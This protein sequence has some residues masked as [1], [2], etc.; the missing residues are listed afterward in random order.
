ME[1]LDRTSVAGPSTTSESRPQNLSASHRDFTSR[2]RT[3][4]H[5]LIPQNS[6]IQKDLLRNAR[7]VHDEEAHIPELGQRSSQGLQVSHQTRV[8]YAGRD[9]PDGGPSLV[10]VFYLQDVFEAVPA[11]GLFVVLHIVLPNGV[12]Q[13]V[14]VL[15]G[16]IVALSKEQRHSVRR[17][18]TDSQDGGFLHICVFASASI[19]VAVGAHHHLGPSRKGIVEVDPQLEE[20]IGIVDESIDDGPDGVLGDLGIIDLL[21]HLLLDGSALDDAFQATLLSLLS[22]LSLVSLVL[23]L[24]LFRKLAPGEP[25]AATADH[26]NLPYWLVILIPVAA[27]AAALEEDDRDGDDSEFVATTMHAMQM[28]PIT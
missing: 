27:A 11:I 2:F 8:G 14:S 4:P 25:S 10:H 26:G 9:G 3:A 5:I 21:S 18:T 1:C 7:L 24:L 22:L 13:T 28:A 15:D 6:G 20:T 19:E 16:L 17:I 12:G 23:V